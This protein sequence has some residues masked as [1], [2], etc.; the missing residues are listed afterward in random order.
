V[1]ALFIATATNLDLIARIAGFSM[2]ATIVLYEPVMVSFKGGT[3]GHLLRNLRVV[4]DK[5]GGNLGFLRACL[6]F[7]V[8]VFLGVYSFFAMALTQRH[9]ALHDVLSRST[10]QISNLADARP[11]HFV[12]ERSEFNSPHLPSAARR[13]TIIAA[14]VGLTFLVLCLALMGLMQTKMLS[15]GCLDRNFCDATERVLAT[16]I[17]IL[18]FIAAAA[19]AY[20][21]WRGRLYGARL[22]RSITR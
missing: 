10:V 5:T 17:S 2:L 19:I 15:A 11:H 7:A 20:F 12:A 3:F 14:Y 9:Q 4:D 21:G 8:K 22:R 16:G 6:R 1:V 18:W 13:L